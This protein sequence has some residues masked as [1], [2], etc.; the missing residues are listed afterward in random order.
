[1]LLI[2]TPNKI[3]I[4]II[5]YKVRN[6]SVR[7]CLP[8]TLTETFIHLLELMLAQTPDRSGHLILSVF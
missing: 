3:I 5:P 6:T 2:R 1:M 7:I 4:V 8:E